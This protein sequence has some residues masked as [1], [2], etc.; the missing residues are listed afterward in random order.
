MK[1]RVQAQKHLKKLQ[2]KALPKERKASA[3]QFKLLECR[4]CRVLAARTE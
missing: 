3:N 2:I 4:V 1:A